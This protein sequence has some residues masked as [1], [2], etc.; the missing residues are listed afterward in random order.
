MAGLIILISFGI[1]TGLIGRAKGSSFI[2]WFCV[3]ATLPV[4]GLLTVILY[5]SEHEEPE[6]PCP[7]C[8]KP[9]KVYVQVCDRCGTDLELPDPSEVRVA[10]KS[11]HA[12]ALRRRA[13]QRQLNA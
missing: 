4:I 12:R 3:G 10:P 5:R 1:S 2:L 8:R 11:R 13:R 7:V 9:L 6:R